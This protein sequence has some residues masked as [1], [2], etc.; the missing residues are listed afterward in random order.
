MFEVIAFVACVVVTV[1][2]IRLR[3]Q[4]LQMPDDKVLRYTTFTGAMKGEAVSI[5]KARERIKTHHWVYNVVRIIFFLAAVALTIA[6]VFYI[7]RNHPWYISYVRVT[8]DSIVIDTKLLLGILLI[9]GYWAVFISLHYAGAV[10][11]RREDALMVKLNSRA[12]AS[13]APSAQ[14]VAEGGAAQLTAQ[15]SPQQPPETGS[16][17]E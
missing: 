2:L 5:E 7:I 16:P 14:P 6:T 15:G 1:L 11:L 4:Y 10:V 9:A 3:D 12:A 13:A 8:S 17:G